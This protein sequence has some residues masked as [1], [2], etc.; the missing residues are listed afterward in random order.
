MFLC[1]KSIFLLL[2]IVFSIVTDKVFFFRVGANQRS[3]LPLNIL[4]GWMLLGGL[5]FKKG[6]RLTNILRWL[7]SIICAIVLALGHFWGA[8]RYFTH[9]VPQTDWVDWRTE[10]A[11][12]RAD[13]DYRMRIL[14]PPWS[15]VLKK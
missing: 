10:V 4:L 11:T 6:K 15:V 5:P 13:P 8:N 2:S 1:S 9:P 12:W 14:P 7:I 3:F